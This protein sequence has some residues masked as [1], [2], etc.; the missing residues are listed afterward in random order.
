M[1]SENIREKFRYRLT[2]EKNGPIKYT[3]HLDLLKIFQ[4]ALRRA[5]LPVRYSKGFNPHSVISFAQPLSVGMG[6]LAEYV[7]IELAELTEPSEI[8]E[9]LNKNLPTGLS[10]LSCRLF[11]PGEKSAAA[12]V[13][14]AIYE[15][16]LKS[17]D[18][19]ILANRLESA[20]KEILDAAEIIVQKDK[21]G[22]ERKPVE[23]E[24]R[25]FIQGI[26]IT[27]KTNV[28]ATVA[29]GGKGNLRPQLLAA[30]IC[31]RAGVGFDAFGT[32]Y[33]RRALIL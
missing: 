30:E 33:E 5:E 4:R 29:C 32:E 21:K 22:G 28:S 6:G 13:S 16:C 2:F 20:V 1:N 10:A 25:R 3:G 11:K 23:T 9:K 27:G 24:I 18:D 8:I 15:I 19:V 26:E 14:A 12:L 17:H 7:E 31:R